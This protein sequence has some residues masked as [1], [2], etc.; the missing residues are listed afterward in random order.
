MEYENLAHNTRLHLSN[1]FEEVK[2][3]LRNL[4][5][6]NGK[7]S[8]TIATESVPKE[9]K[10]RLPAAF[11][12]LELLAHMVQSLSRQTANSTKIHAEELNRFKEEH[13]SI[14]QYLAICTNAYNLAKKHRPNIFAYTDSA[15]SSHQF[16]MSTLEDLISF[17]WDATRSGSEQ[18]LGRTF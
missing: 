3:K 11:S 1:R 8:A 15:D 10:P 5:L 14:T 12:Q 4:S 9:F 17:E 6:H 7:A 2:Q 13:D 16:T 18:G